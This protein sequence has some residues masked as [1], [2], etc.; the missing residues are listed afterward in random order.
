MG[1]MFAVGGWEMGS[2]ADTSFSG[3]DYS[4]GYYEGSRSG[5][6]N[7]IDNGNMMPNFDLRGLPNLV[8]SGSVANGND[9]S[10]YAMFADLDAIKSVG[11]GDGYSLVLDESWFT[12]NVVNFREAFKHCDRLEVVDLATISVANNFNFRE[13][14]RDCAKLKSSFWANT[15]K[16][17]AR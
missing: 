2:G 3:W 11:F 12:S 7:D 15:A 16:V 10:T 9:G 17:R 4:V 5:E 14:F 6:N 1:A 8:P 13:G